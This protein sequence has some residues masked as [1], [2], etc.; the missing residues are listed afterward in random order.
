MLMWQHWKMC[1][2]ASGG[3]QATHSEGSFLGG[4]Q[5]GLQ[6]LAVQAMGFPEI[7]DVQAIRHSS[8][9]IDNAEEVPLRVT[10]GAAVW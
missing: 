6:P 1:S 8:S 9:A 3:M 4:V 10:I 7:V 2:E 5:Q